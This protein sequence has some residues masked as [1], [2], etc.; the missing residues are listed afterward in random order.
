M[1]GIFGFVGKMNTLEILNRLESL[2]YRG[3]D[4][5]GVAYISNDSIS[6]S[7]SVGNVSSLRFNVDV[8]NCQMAIGHTRW[9]THGKVSVLNAHPHTTSNNR[10][11]ITHNGMIDNYKEIIND[12]NIKLS[13]NTDSEVIAH[14]LDNLTANNE[15]LEAVDR[16]RYIL[17]GSYAIVF[18]DMQNKNRLYFLKK[19]SPLLIAKT[20]HNV[21]IASDQL[22][23]DYKANVTILNENDYG[24][25]ELNEINILPKDSNRISF[26]KEN[27]I[28][29]IKKSDHFLYDEIIH[30][31]NMVLNISKA[32]ENI[33]ISSFENLIVNCD[34]IVFVG[35]GSSCFACAILASLFEKKLN[36]R[37]LFIV[38]SEF[39]SF[40]MFNNSVY[41]LLSQ[42][43]E[44]ADLCNALNI[45]K[46]N[47]LPIISLC[48]NNYSTLAYNSDY[49][50]PLLAG[51]EISVASTK[52]FTA[53]LYVGRI[54]LDKNECFISS[55]LSYEINCILN[56]SE[57]IYD[58]AKRVISK[59][60]IFYIGKGIDYFICQE[61]ALKIREISYLNSYAFQ[62]GELKHGSIALVDTNTIAIAISTNDSELDNIKNNLEE[63]N[64]RG[65]E[66]VL[67]SNSDENASYY[68]PYDRISIVVFVQLLAYY[69]ALLLNRNIDQP[70]NLAKSVTVL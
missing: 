42:S 5:C 26:V 22:A 64:S 28:S 38:A 30:Q 40:N 29:Q 24:F 3:Y 53:M 70:R 8:C 9:A 47:N 56:M 25:I 45:I 51:A 32:Y 12:Y 21:M 10:F 61:A 18:I 62:S 13:S 17:K 59:K 58:L 11:I 60:C 27:S 46:Q 37:S 50:F 23:F 6:I 43:G 34:E 14:L 52:A 48:N 39:S 16:L 49:V 36:K 1:C 7:K 2:E 68:L 31:K 69:S 20:D 35:A 44:T 41:I 54:L 15:T 67:I 65:G 4:S 33:D 19:A 66:V 63:I 57:R 55:K